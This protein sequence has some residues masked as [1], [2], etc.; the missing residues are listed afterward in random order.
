MR[1]RDRMA[2]M[3][4]PMLDWV[5]HWR[6]MNENMFELVD[7]FPDDALSWVPRQGEWPAPVIFTHVVMAR[8]M[9]PLATPEWTA[10]IGQVPSNC[11]TKGGI[12]DELLQS[13]KDIERFLADEANL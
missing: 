11:R 3:S 12:K 1:S 2:A 8:H 6:M 5:P 10:R 13:W 9:G 7:L 4:Y